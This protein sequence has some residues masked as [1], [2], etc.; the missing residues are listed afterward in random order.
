MS[1]T[2]AASTQRS[3]W[4]FEWPELKRSRRRDYAYM[5]RDEYRA[6]QIWLY[7]LL[8]QL[9][10]RLDVRQRTV[11][12]AAVFL[13]R[14]YTRA[15]LL[16]TDPVLMCAAALYLSSKVCE[17]PLH[18]RTLTHEAYLLWG[19]A[20]FGFVEEVGRVGE[21]EFFLISELDAELVLHLPYAA[22]EL[23]SDEDTSNALQAQDIQAA[24]SLV[25][26]CYASDVPLLFPPH[27]IAM[28]CLSIV[29]TSRETAI[30]GNSRNGA[31]V[32]TNS[33]SVKPK[34]VSRAK[35]KNAAP[36][37]VAGKTV[38]GMDALKSSSYLQRLFETKLVDPTA[39]ARC[40]QHIISLDMFARSHYV[41]TPLQ[42]SPED[43][44]PGTSGSTSAN[45]SGAQPNAD[46]SALSKSSKKRSASAMETP[47]VAAH[48]LKANS[49]GSNG[50]DDTAEPIVMDPR[51]ILV[52]ARGL[53]ERDVATGV[54]SHPAAH[55]QR[56]PVS[57][58]SAAAAATASTHPGGVTTMASTGTSIP[59]AA[60]FAQSAP[61]GISEMELRARAIHAYHEAQ[62]HHQH[63]PPNPISQPT[64]ASRLQERLAAMA[65]G[66]GGGSSGSPGFGVAGSS[67]LSRPASAAS[68]NP[69][70]VAQDTGG[71]AGPTAESP[72]L[73]VPEV[74]EIHYGI[75]SFNGPSYGIPSDPSLTLTTH[76]DTSRAHTTP[77]HDHPAHDAATKRQK[78]YDDKDIDVIDID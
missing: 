71:V 66:G 56:Q 2:W 11:A 43:I 33:P 36:G 6:I 25:N 74:G 77:S 78:T 70:R 48:D 22:L 15:S 57:T 61:Q 21:A 72:A 12:T 42:P 35:N 58:G 16:E 39:V 63:H 4:T 59:S 34:P 50:Q 7:D 23:V 55:S 62:Q 47:P 37:T 73:E 5:T 68:L 19:G 65:H 54:S 30:P 1:T 67:P 60:S 40:C 27:I 32:S 18:I 9:A 24:W 20:T 28:A 76:Q 17:S 13:T 44:L 69:Q 31:S 52:R 53:W 10:K 38:P 29:I 64:H 45:G 8:R 26:F 75:S 51:K 49:S 14:F 3:H 41:V 46:T